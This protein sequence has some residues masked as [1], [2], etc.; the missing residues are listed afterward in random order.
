MEK[1]SAYGAQTLA[2][3]VRKE[4][5]PRMAGPSPLQRVELRHL[6]L[7]LARTMGPSFRQVT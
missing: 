7:S 4:S 3:R 2:S 5:R 1:I 6:K